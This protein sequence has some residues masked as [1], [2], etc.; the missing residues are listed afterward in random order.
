[1]SNKRKAAWSHIDIIEGGDSEFD[2]LGTVEELTN[3]NEEDLA[4][5]L[6]QPD[7]AII[8]AKKKKKKSRQTSDMTTNDDLNTGT[9]T[10]RN[11]DEDKLATKATTVK[12]LQKSKQKRKNKK[13]MK[14]KM[15]ILNDDKDGDKTKEISFDDSQIKNDSTLPSVDLT[16]I[17]DQWGNKGI[18]DEILRALAEK[19]FNHPTEIQKIC[20]PKA[21]G[22]KDVVGA[23][24]TGSGKTLA[25]GI[26]LVANIM[27]IK[28]RHA[29]RNKNDE[30]CNLY[31]V[32]I[33]PTRELALQIQS[34][35]KE[36][37]KYCDIKLCSVIGGLAPEKQQRLLSYHPEIVVATPGRLMKMLSSG[38]EHLQKISN[39]RFLIIDECDR[40]FEKGH[41]A[42]LKTI[43]M[44]M[45]LKDRKVQKLVFSATLS[46]QQ[47]PKKK[48]YDE[49]C[50]SIGLT[51]KVDV[52]DLTTKRVT[53]EQLQQMKVICEDNEKEI[54]LLYFLLHFTGRTIIFANTI[55][56]TDRIS[57]LLKV[58][59]FSPYQ[60]HAKKQ[61]KQRLS[62][63]DA[64]RKSENGIL[65]CTDVAAHGLDIPEVDNIVHFQLPKDPKIYVHRCGRTARANK[66]GRSLILNGSEDF[67]GFKNISKLLKE[68]EMENMVVD[69]IVYKSLKERITLGKEIERKMY[70]QKKVSSELSWQQRMSKQL[71]IDTDVQSVDKTGK[72]ALKVKQNQL[73]NLLQVNPVAEHKKQGHFKKSG[74]ITISGLAL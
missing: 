10:E 28:K 64:F 42:E 43:L 3:Y 23:A 22:F 46:L 62:C 44:Q 12:K 52:V 60:L 72:K 6:S 61:Q 56:C 57:R 7:E 14:E 26:P 58:L 16:E 32:I 47:S 31:G 54:Y 49:L 41:F 45:N 29:E 63:L 2:S 53:V 40:M 36:I 13:N 20:I 68:N 15:K 55:A 48:F 19:K 8:P 37:T 70:H 65:V 1:M 17:K 24:E 25:F 27:Q 67:E 66:N 4:K 35:L 34:H 38:N 9:V 59:E 30:S 73:K 71:G 18:P 11:E 50:E 51:G 69:S 33:A 5:I 74:T 21:I 39:I